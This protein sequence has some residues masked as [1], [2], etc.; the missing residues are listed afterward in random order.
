[1]LLVHAQMCKYYFGYRFLR[2]NIVYPA[3]VIGL[4][5]FRRYYITPHTIIRYI[6]HGTINL[7]L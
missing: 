7:P 1:M 6:A 3:Y 4:L 2:V 5:P